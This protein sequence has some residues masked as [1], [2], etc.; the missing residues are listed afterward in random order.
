MSTCLQ[1][2]AHVYNTQKFENNLRV[3]IFSQ[4][5]FSRI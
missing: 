2:E 3:L 4:V 1:N 5:L